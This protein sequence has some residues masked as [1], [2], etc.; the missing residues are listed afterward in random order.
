MFQSC[1]DQ[2]HVRPN[3]HEQDA[4]ILGHIHL[5]FLAHLVKRSLELKLRAA[6]CTERGS[7]FLDGFSDIALN[8]PEI[9]GQ[10]QPLITELSDQQRRKARQAGVQIPQGPFT[11]TLRKHLPTDT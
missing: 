5:T 7:S 4:N 1:K 3:F 8:E 6:G 10:T 11:G 2:L 9:A